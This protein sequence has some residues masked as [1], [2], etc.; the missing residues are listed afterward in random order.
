MPVGVKERDWERELFT[1]KAGTTKAGLL[2]QSC[3]VRWP[4]SAV[5]KRGERAEP[6]Y[7]SSASPLMGAALQKE[8]QTWAMQLSSPERKSQRAGQ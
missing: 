8:V 3:R 7:S 2:S 1:F 4:F 5:L 6:L